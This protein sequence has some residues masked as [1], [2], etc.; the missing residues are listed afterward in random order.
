[1]LTYI[2]EE[3]CSE[4]MLASSNTDVQTNLDD[5][6]GN[7]FMKTQDVFNG[8]PVYKM[9]SDSRYCVWFNNDRKMNVGYCSNL[10][11]PLRVNYG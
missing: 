8:K 9:S 7:T 10:E 2:S 11:D 1:M 6:I 5:Y 4:F 3:C